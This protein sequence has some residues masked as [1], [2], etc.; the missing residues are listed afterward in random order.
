[1]GQEDD[2]GSNVLPETENVESDLSD[3]DQTQT[4]A[5]NTGKGRD[6]EGKENEESEPAP[7]EDYI[8]SEIDNIIQQITSSSSSE[9]LFK[10]SSQGTINQ[11]LEPVLD[12][13]EQVDNEQVNNEQVNNEQVDNGEQEKVNELE[14]MINDENIADIADIDV[15]E[16]QRVTDEQSDESLDKKVTF[17]DTDMG[18]IFLLFFINIECLFERMNHTQVHYKILNFFRI[19]HG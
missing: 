1:M 7:L 9:D 13:K 16:P 18:N 15:T 11:N 19:L 2:K 10:D 6:I 3:T 8:L 14:G 4:T 5:Y 17:S 12:N